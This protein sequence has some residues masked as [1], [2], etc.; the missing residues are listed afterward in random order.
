[1]TDYDYDLGILGG[2]AA[3]LTVAAGAAQFGAKTLLIEREEK[4]GGDCLHYGCVPSKTLIRTASV[5]AQAR[6]SREFGL[7]EVELP[8]VDLKAVMDRVRAVIA[9]IQEHDS[10]ERFCNLG[11]ETRFGPARFLDDHTVEVDGSR[12]SAKSWVIATGSRPAAP[13]VE[14]IEAVP[15]WTNE[16]LFAQT[17][18]PDRL[19]VLGGGAIGLEMAQAFQRLG[20]KVILVEFLDQIL[21]PEDADVA[22]ILKERL[23][24]EGME[25]LTGTRA[26]QAEGNAESVRLSVEPAA[27]GGERRVLEGDVLLVA[28]G[29]KPN[30]EG[31]GLEAAG[32]EF[33][34][35]GIPT[36][37]RMRTNLH[38]IYACGDV[39]GK[40]QFTHMAGYAGG[41]A[42]TNAILHLPR[43]ADFSKVPWCTY[44]DPEVASVGFNEKRARQEKI[45]YRVLEEKFADN[46]RALAENEAGGKIKVL[47]DGKGKVI[48]CQIVG[49]HAG[50]LIHEWI[51]VISGGVKLSTIAG[52]IHV[53][54][55]LAEISK[56]AAGSY[57]SD[58]LFSDRTKSVL[59]FLFHLK[60]RACTPT[61]PSAEAK[62]G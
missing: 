18:L 11:A 35:K 55:T 38:H 3:G 39:T 44:T 21:P 58:K 52:A 43:K 34:A 23:Q 15:Y 31:L 54:P 53:Y 37:A 2:G 48:G 25:I 22:E 50:E 17:R 47:V 19:L 27:G 9:R 41:V 32:V 12:V 24:S 29:R 57:F 26:V 45:E 7:P 36:D 51:A 40:F 46:D 8:P 30:V 33:S 1:M 13:P 10:P 59:K 28:T 14:G 56:R 4:L 5:W 20:S 6:R 49:A 16:T 61:E 42:L 62:H 60:G